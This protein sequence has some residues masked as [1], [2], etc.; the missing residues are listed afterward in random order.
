ME[1]KYDDEVGIVLKLRY[2]TSKEHLMFRLTT[3]VEHL[4]YLLGG[5][6]NAEDG[7]ADFFLD[8]HNCNCGL[9][10]QKALIVDEDFDRI[11]D[12]CE[13][14]GVE[15]ATCMSLEEYEKEELDEAEGLIDGLGR[16]D[17]PSKEN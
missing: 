12:W 3:F 17:G 14:K 11:L 4:G 15:V 6:W 13:E 7:E 2:P 16:E 1:D 10:P 8:P 5:G 9:S